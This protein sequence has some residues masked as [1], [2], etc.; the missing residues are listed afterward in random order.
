MSVYLLSIEYH[1]CRVATDLLSSHIM[2]TSMAMGFM[3]CSLSAGRTVSPNEILF[4][5]PS[6]RRLSRK[7]GTLDVSNPWAFTACY[8]DSFTF[9]PLVFMFIYCRLDKTTNIV[10]C[11]T[12]NET[13]DLSKQQC[14]CCAPALDMAKLIWL[15]I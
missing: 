15:T 11:I 4:S 10:F 6:V 9:L 13:V 2:R 14:T 7:C 3:K 8:R 5:P 1:K 12:V